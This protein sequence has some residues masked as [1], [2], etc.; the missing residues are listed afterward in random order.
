MVA[1]IVTCL[2]VNSDK[3]INR[4]IAKNKEKVKKT[5]DKSISNLIARIFVVCGPI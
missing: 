4:L 1:S 3:A 2:I 5:E